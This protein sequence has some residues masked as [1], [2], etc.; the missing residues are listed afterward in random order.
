MITIENTPNQTTLQHIQALEHLYK[1]GWRDEV[2]AL[3]LRK[4]LERQLEQDQAQL[5][6]LA[7]DLAKFER[8]FGMS[9]EEFYRQYQA[10][11]MGD[12]MDVFE[13]N[14]F[15]RMYGRLKEQVAYLQQQLGL[16]IL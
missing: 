12:D 1:Q 8:Q 5:N 15:Y 10:G 2:A 16:K 6:E 4:L 11:K 13:W 7:Q 3:T 9:S 14:V